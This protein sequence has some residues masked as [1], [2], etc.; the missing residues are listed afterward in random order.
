MPRQKDDVRKVLGY[1]P[2]DFGVYPRTT[3]QEMYDQIALLKGAGNAPNGK[4]W[5]NGC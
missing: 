1:L 5:W 4:N 3:A 2:Q